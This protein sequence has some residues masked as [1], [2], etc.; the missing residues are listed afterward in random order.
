MTEPE[1]LKEFFV[2]ILGFKKFSLPANLIIIGI[3]VAGVRT[4][5][6]IFGMLSVSYLILCV[7]LHIFGLYF[8][9]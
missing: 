6:K 5:R 2:D 7:R 4:P 8:L 9:I 3:F 1:K